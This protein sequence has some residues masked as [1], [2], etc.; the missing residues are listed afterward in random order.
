[1]TAP[2]TRKAFCARLTG[3]TVVLLIQACGGGGSSY[4]MP[5]NPGPAGATC[6]DTIAGNHGHVLT[7]PTADLD[8]T[9]DK[10][11]DIQGS[12]I[13]THSVTLTVA[14]L[15]A[16]KAGMNTTVISSTSSDGPAGAHEHSVAI[17]CA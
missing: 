7:I 4:Q 15:Q 3:C 17:L 11:Y 6:N 10:V 8:A 2:M 14:N 12:A 5:A 1:M 13:H 16:L 9:V